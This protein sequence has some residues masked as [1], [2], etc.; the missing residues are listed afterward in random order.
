MWKYFHRCRKGYC[1]ADLQDMD[2]WFM[3]VVP[4]MLRQFAARKKG[5]PVAFMQ[6]WFVQN[7]EKLGMSYEEFLA[8][9]DHEAIRRQCEAAWKEK[10][11]QIA[12]DFDLAWYHYTSCEEGWLERAEAYKNQ[13]FAE[14]SKWFFYLWE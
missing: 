13:A 5:C 11:C 6:E 2:Q 8:C 7:Q 9:E 1:E 3:S 10:I 14:F 4:P 12:D